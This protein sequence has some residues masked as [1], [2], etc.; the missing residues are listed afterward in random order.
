MVS[1]AHE[2][3]AGEAVV[4]LEEEQHGLLARQRPQVDARRRGRDVEGGVEQVAVDRRDD[5]F[6]VGD[7]RTPNQDFAKIRSW[8]LWRLY[9][10]DTWRVHPRLTFNYGLRYDVEFLPS[11]PPST[12][13]AGAAYKTL[14]L[15]KGIPLSPLNFAPRIGLAWAPAG[16]GA[17]AHPKTVLRAGFGTFYDRFALANTITALHYN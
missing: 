17:N 13:L 4:V 8:P 2:H 5:P 11:Y 10:Q 9:L 1:N 15:T 14:G 6:G 7:G 3:G 12:V 16:G